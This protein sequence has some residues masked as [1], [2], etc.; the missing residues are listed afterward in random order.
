MHDGSGD[1]AVAAELAARLAAAGIAVGTVTPVESAISAVRSAEA[2]R[3]QA[4]ALAT[5]LGLAG[6]EPDGAAGA[7]VLVV[8]RDDHAVLL[9]GDPGC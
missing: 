3:P 2:Q 4:E 7:V 8:G 9:T 1:P 6:V 5:V